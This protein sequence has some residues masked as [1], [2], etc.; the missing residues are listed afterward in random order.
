MLNSETAT[1]QRDRVELR[2]ANAQSQTTIHGWPSFIFGIPFA[3]I[4]VAGLLVV[5]G[6]IPVEPEKIKGPTWMIGVFAGFF[7]MA[8]LSFWWHG[9]KGVRRKAAIASG[10][11]RAPGS[12][13]EWDYPWDRIGFRGN[14]LGQVIKTFWGFVV[15]AVFLSPFNWWA[16]VSDEG[17][18]FVRVVVGI[19]D[20]I[21]VA[22]LGQ[23]VYQLIQFFKYGN[24][25]LLYHAFPFY[26]GDKMSIGLE[27]LPTPDKIEELVLDL[28]FIEERY[29]MRGSGKNRSSQVICY[30]LYRETRTLKGSELVFA[31]A[32]EMEWGLPTDDDLNS[33]LSE[34]PAKFWEL[35]VEAKTPGVDYHE[36]FLLPVYAKP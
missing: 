6:V 11:V 30:E 18:T 26:L 10:K 32:L 22:I 16:F 1:G 3:L 24:S 21:T 23:F 28:R 34:R 7:L 13:W 33:G 15:F 19:F 9:L 17:T 35:E 29:E 2:G 20:V 12:P 25:R 4:G 8:G 27:G 36:R 14:K 5:T 31:S